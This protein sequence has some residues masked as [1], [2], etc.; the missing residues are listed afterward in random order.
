MVVWSQNM[1]IFTLL[2]GPQIM[3]YMWIY[4]ADGI[5]ALE[6]WSLPRSNLEN[7]F[8]STI[9]SS[10]CCLLDGYP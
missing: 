5:L 2:R 8:R 1:L 6:C 10:N 7:Q 4:S 3:R 9:M